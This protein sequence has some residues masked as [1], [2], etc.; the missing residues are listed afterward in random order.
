MTVRLH[1]G[2]PLALVLGWAGLGT[3]CTQNPSN[4]TVESR[5][6]ADWS[7]RSPPAPAPKP[8]APVPVTPPAAAKAASP[9]PASAEPLPDH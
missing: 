6:V 1:V 7:K 9:Q 2:L 5:S 4:A 8:A 3:G